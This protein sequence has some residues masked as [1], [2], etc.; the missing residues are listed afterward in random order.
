MRTPTY[1][2]VIGL[3]LLLG[4]GAAAVVLLVGAPRDRAADA[5]VRQEGAPNAWPRDPDALQRWLEEQP[6]PMRRIRAWLEY[7]SMRHA[8]GRH[9]EAARAWREA[10]R[11][12]AEAA[13]TGFE[14]FNVPRSWYNFAC[15]RAR[16]GDADGAFEALAHAAEHGFGD[17]DRARGDPDLQSLRGD[18]RF[19]AALERMARNPRV[20][21]AG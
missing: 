9:D 2:A 21:N 1:G 17:A 8:Q 14:G 15:V 11:R 20:F 5:R 4:V 12:Y 16:L 19:E 6:E 13:A 7:G 10:E 18:A 3:A